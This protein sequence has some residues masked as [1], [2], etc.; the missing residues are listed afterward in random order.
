MKPWYYDLKLLLRSK[1]AVG[2][3]VL[4]LVLTTASL[5]SGVQRIDS[6]R[7]AIARIGALHAEDTAAVVSAHGDSVDAGTAAYYS[8]QPTWNPPSPLAFAAVG[9]RDVAPIMLR[10]RALGLEAQ[11]HDGDTFNPELALAGRFDFSFLL[12]FLLPLFVIAL[13][14]DLR[15]SETESGRERMLRSLPFRTRWLYLRRSIIRGLALWLCVGV[16]FVVVAISQGVPAGQILAVLALAAAYL[17]FWVVLCL[18]ISR[19]AWNSG[20]NAAALA[21]CWVVLALVAPALAN[22]GIE[23]AIPVEQGA[24]IARAQREAV[25]GAWDIPRDRTMQQF[26]ASHPQWRDSAPLGDAFHYKWYLAFHQNGDDQVAPLVAAYRDG[27]ERRNA[28]AAA[29]GWVLPSVG[30]QV[31]LTRMAGTDMQAHLAYQDRIRRYHERLRQF[32]Y[33][34]LFTDKPFVKSDYDRVPP[35]EPG[36]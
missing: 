13:L 3:L 22:V 1:V 17:L 30:L 9:M 34:Y 24:T 2:S 5:L 4:L 26:Y 21:S 32:F 14:H 33:G 27:I 23:R 7:E 8:F 29:V 28:A 6:Q 18:L 10:V 15:S 25:N 12:T 31:A 19:R 11:I 16:P 35:F 36:E 20:V